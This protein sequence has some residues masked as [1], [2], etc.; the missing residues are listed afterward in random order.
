M[1]RI[2]NISWLTA[3]VVGLMVSCQES[4]VDGFEP[5]DNNGYVSVSFKAQVPDMGEIRTKAVDPD[6]QDITKILLFCFNERGLFISVEEAD[7]TTS[8]GTTGTYDVELP[9]VTDRVHFIA[10]LHKTINVDDFLGMSESQVLSTMEGSSGMMTYWARVTKGAHADIKTA[11]SA[12]HNPVQLLRDHARVTVTDNSSGGLYED[13]AFVVINTNA[14]GTVAPFNEGNWVAPKLDN[15]FITLPESS[16]RV[17]GNTDVVYKVLDTGGQ[18]QYVFETENSSENPVCVIIRGT[19]KTTGAVKYFRVMLI[20]QNGEFVPIMRNFTYNVQITGEMDYGQDSFDA[21]LSAPATNNI[22]LSVADDVKEISSSEYT[23]GV[24]ETH[25]VLGEDDE[26]FSTIHKQLTVHYSLKSLTD[27]DLTAEDKPVI[28]WLD[29][30]DVAQQTIDASTFVISADGKSAEGSV[31]I[32]LLNLGDLKKREGTLLIKKGLLERRVKIVTVAEQKFE[33][34]WITT[35]IYGAE[36]GS[37]VTMMFHVSEDCP[38]ELFPLDVLVTVNDLDVRDESGMS[39]PIIRAGEDGYGEDNGIGYKYVLTVTEPGNQRLYL[40]TILTHEVT[41]T[42]EVTIEAEHFQPVTKTATFQIDTDYRILIH[43]L[44]S[45]SAVTPADEVIYYYL[46]PQKINAEVEFNTHLGQVY[47]TNPG[48]GNYDGTF[49]DASEKTYWVNYVDA[50]VDY[51]GNNVDEFLMYSEYLVH[52]H[53]KPSGTPFYFYFYEI[54]EAVWNIST[55]GRVMGFI[56]NATTASDG[57]GGAVFHLKTN[58]P[59]AEEV[60]RIATNPKGQKSVTTGDPGDHV[61]A[62]SFTYSSESCTGEGRYKS[63]VFDLSTFHPFHFSAQVKQGSTLLAGGAEYNAVQP[64]TETILLSYEPGQNINVEFDVTSFKSNITGV[65]SD[66]QLSV[67]P[68]GTGFDIYIDAPTLE[69]DEAAVAAAGLS[70][71]IRIDPA[72]PGRVIYTV[73]ADRDVERTNGK[74]SLAA[75]ATDNATKHPVTRE[76]ITVDQ[77]G[78]RKS[79]PFLTKDIVSASDITISSDESKVVYYTKTFKIQNKPMTGTLTYGSSATPIPA[80]TFVPFSRVDDDTRIGV[81]TVGE[82]GTFNL[83][84]RAEYEFEWDTPVQFECSIDGVEYKCDNLKL[85][86]V[87]TAGTINLT[88]IP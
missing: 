47:D 88:Q 20:D 4:L 42:V 19:H 48:T 84:L 28:T 58:T 25:I 33:P 9:V 26:V 30:N 83:R 78:E 45:Y 38:Q 15:M 14:F 10:N 57:N 52:N 61:T 29:G 32:T 21:A 37:N 74:S 85:S 3:V 39:L 71:K 60:V 65:A 53:D 16:L 55:A 18:Y 59:K 72:I 7:L 62:D 50:N 31:D 75:L 77:T 6:G 17:T 80:E 54:D 12:E 13:L 79:I 76:T 36:T 87:A 51:A 70:G 68:F 5:T 11:L 27:T 34:V 24:E 2:F 23:L 81:I 44:R 63:V 64:E 43:N 66:D 22:W 49:T 41:E 40:E 35:N 67:D 8:S 46:V 1:K 82:N 56:R 86:D 73:D 69:L